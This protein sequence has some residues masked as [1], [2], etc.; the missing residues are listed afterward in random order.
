M[1]TRVQ[2]IICDRV[3]DRYGI[4][5][6]LFNSAS[7]VVKFLNENNYDATLTAVV[8]SNSI[9]RAV[10]QFNPD[11]VVI[12]ALWVPPAKFEELLKIKRHSNRKWIVRI[13]SKA[14]FLAN[15]GL[16]TKWIQQYAS[17]EQGPGILIAPNTKELTEQLH[18][19]FPYGQFVFL[20]NVYFSEKFEPEIYNRDPEWVDVGCFGAIRPMKNN[21]QQA[22]AA[23]EFANQLGKRLRFHINATRLEQTGDNALKNLRSL[24]YHSPHDLVEHHWYKHRHFLKAASKMDVGMQVSFSESFNI[25]S[26]DFVTARVPIVVSDDIEWLPSLL[27]TTPTSHRGMVKMLHRAYSWRT[28]SAWWQKIFLKFYNIRAEITWLAAIRQINKQN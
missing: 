1:K 18:S 17:I 28:L 21:F 5:S 4:T 10:T 24:F 9:D 15:E 2:F 22:L 26:A 13:H 25:V 19:A 6:G 16:A 11:I 14:P 3:K 12:E 20:P 7:F 23:I 27:K 8:D